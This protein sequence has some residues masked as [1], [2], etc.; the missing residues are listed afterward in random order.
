MKQG[1]TLIETV[2][3]TGIFTMIVVILIA[4]FARF[5]SVERRD[6]AEQKLLEEIRFAVE[7]FSR[8]A[9]TAY[10]STYSSPDG[11]GQEVI[12]RNQNGLCVHYRLEEARLE[13][14]E[15]DVPGDTC[16]TAQFAGGVYASVTGPNTTLEAFEFD[17][18]PASVVDGELT[19]QGFI[20][21]TLAAHS[22]NPSVGLLRAQ[23][24]VTSRQVVPY[25]S[26]LE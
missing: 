7:L 8:E 23:T 22:S 5:T 18:V 19:E 20:T 6:I 9:R 12:F 15:R 13:R 14:A 1:F 21:I 2:V 3:A 17:V 25:T 10:S 24:T 4:L 16:S 26:E 11:S